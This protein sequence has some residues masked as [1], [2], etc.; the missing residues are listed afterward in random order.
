MVLPEWKYTKREKIG[1]VV[2]VLIGLTIFGLGIVLHI[3]GLTEFG[4]FILGLCIVCYI[5]NDK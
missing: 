1:M 5:G 3:D 2:V 4:M